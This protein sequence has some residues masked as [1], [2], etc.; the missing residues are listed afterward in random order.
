[1]REKERWKIRER[2]RMR[3]R[4][5]K[6]DKEKEGKREDERKRKRD[7]RDESLSEMHTGIVSQ[8]GVREAKGR[9]REER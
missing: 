7:R 6:Q 8:R 4:Q 3:E 9:E 5:T 2:R 1:M